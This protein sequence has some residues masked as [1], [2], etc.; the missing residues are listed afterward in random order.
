MTRNIRE[1]PFTEAVEKLKA[2]DD[3]ADRRREKWGREQAEK[4]LAR[5]P[6]ELRA[7]AL[8]KAGIGGETV[9]VAAGGTNNGMAASLLA[10]VP[11]RRP[12][13]RLEIDRAK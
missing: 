3:E 4:I 7:L 10:P 13:E 8:E 11:A 6:P 12:G 9:S 1:L 5:I 2:I